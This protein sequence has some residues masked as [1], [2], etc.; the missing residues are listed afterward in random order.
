[1]NANLSPDNFIIEEAPI[2]GKVRKWH[3]KPFAKDVALK[4]LLES[5]KNKPNNLDL[6]IGIY[7]NY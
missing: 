4:E 5:Q 6:Q 1:M 2:R 3:Y 7:E